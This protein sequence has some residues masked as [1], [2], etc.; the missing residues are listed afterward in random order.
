M[1]SYVRTYSCAKILM[2]NRNF[3]CVAVVVVVVYIPECNSILKRYGCYEFPALVISI[4]SS[5]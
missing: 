2:E 1:Y 3:Q 5:A 4:L